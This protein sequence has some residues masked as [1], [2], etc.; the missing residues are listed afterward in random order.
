MSKCSHPVPFSHPSLEARQAQLR[1]EPLTRHPRLGP[2]G[3]VSVDEMPI[4][5]DLIGLRPLTM[6][7]Q[8]ARFDHGVTDYR[9]IPDENFLSED[10]FHDY[11]D[12]LPPDGLSPYEIAGFENQAFAYEIGRE[13]AQ[14]KAPEA[15]PPPS[16]T[17]L[18]EGG[19]EGPHEATPRT[20]DTADKR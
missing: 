5:V 14:P 6:E 1:G 7:E 16:G 19:R 12:D 18:P 9:L 15:S 11:L 20:P 4:A 8:I 3:R 2:D 13:H 10:D 17:P